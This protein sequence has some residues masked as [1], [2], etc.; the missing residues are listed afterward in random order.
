VATGT[1]FNYFPTK[2]DLINSLYFEVKGNLSKSIREGFECENSF[3]D[4][5]KKM[6]SNLIKW[7]VR[8]PQE[9]LFTEQFCSSP[10]IS[11]LT[12]DEVMKEYAFFNDIVREGIYEG[13]LRES[14]QELIMSMLF[15]SGKTVVR[16][17]LNSLESLDGDELNDLI[18]N[19]FWLI[20]GGLANKCNYNLSSDEEE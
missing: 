13:L 1:L 18:E 7:G 6:W 16:L 15:D 19:S 9:F 14:P 11:K 8:N 17:I 12:R 3:Q 4:K 10:Y 20:W 2:E 5:I